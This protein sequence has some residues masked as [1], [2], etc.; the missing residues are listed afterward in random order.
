MRNKS[1]IGV[2]TVLLVIACVYQLSFTFF[3]KGVEN[4]AI[5]EAKSQW[6]LVQLSGNTEVVLGVDTITVEGGKEDV[7]NH[8]EGKYISE[9]SGDAIYPFFGIS[10]QKCKDQELGL[11]LDLQ[12]GMSVTLEVSIPELLKNLAGNSPKA[13]FKEPLRWQ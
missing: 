4:E 9:H 11:G 1:A 8:Y 13:S 5:V 2:F 3:T 7:M 12:G 6:D 10:Y